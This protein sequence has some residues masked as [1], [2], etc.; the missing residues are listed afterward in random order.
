MTELE[1]IE[2]YAGLARGIARRLGWHLPG[3][4]LED[5]EQ[6]A[7]LGLLLA[8][9]G[10]RAGTDVPFPAF[11]AI[12]V[13][14]RL[15]DALR[16]AS[17]RRQQ[18]L[19]WARRSLRNSEGEE[20]ELAQLLPDPIGLEQLLEARERLRAIVAAAGRLTPLE[21]RA[22]FGLAAGYS[23]AELGDGLK[24]VDNAIQSGRRKLRAA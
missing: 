12:C 24:R 15:S 6:E 18:P 7:C 1:L 3:A 14:R 9:R 21:R 5:L 10:Y 8:A 13:R 11:A 4:E 23:Y 17:S 16:G 22:L 2:S 19:T 20:L